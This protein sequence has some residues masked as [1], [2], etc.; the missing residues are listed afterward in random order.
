MNLRA[1]AQVSILKIVDDQSVTCR[2]WHHGEMLSAGA[3]LNI[4]WGAAAAGQSQVASG[5]ARSP[6]LPA[7][8]KFIVYIR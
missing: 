4:E 2:T 5:Q 1:K 6:L 3:G 7:I 8:N